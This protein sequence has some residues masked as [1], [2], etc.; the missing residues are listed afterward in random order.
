MKKVL[1]ITPYYPPFPKPGA[2]KRVENFVR[3]LP[4]HG[5]DP[6]LIT[7]DWGYPD[8][9]EMAGRKFFFTRN[10]ARMS[11]RAY[12]IT[13]VEQRR[14]VSSWMIKKMIA[15][16]RT[17]KSYLL[18]PDELILWLFWVVWRMREI[19]RTVGFDVL[20]TTAPPNSSLLVAV[21]AKKLFRIPLICDVRDDWCDNPLM[22]KKSSLLRHIE[23]RME[24]WVVDNAD[25]IILVT[26]SS[27]ELWARR[28]PAH[29]HKFVLVPNGY[30]EEE[31]QAASAYVYPAVA[32]VHV[33]SLELNRSPELVYQALARMR[34][35][36]RIDFYQYGLVLREF[37]DKA[38]EYG[39]SDRVHFEGIIPAA[40]TISRI[41]GA[42]MLVLLPTQNAPTAIPGKTYEYLRTGKPILLISAENATT[43]FMKKF[44]Q[45]YQVRPG[46]IGGCIDA[47][48]KASGCGLG[49]DSG[50]EAADSM[51]QYDRRSLAGD[52]AL[53]FDH[54]IENRHMRQRSCTD[55]T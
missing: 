30:S 14:S 54:V 45:V 32:L 47:I 49:T 18:V 50:P 33:G 17:V 42:S 6:V 37:Q 35:R 11:W 21:A 44:P 36:Q 43:Q 52:L 24:R 25:R 8:A 38:A 2:T 1:I 4:E 22:E 10:I 48:V 46:D 53:A 7:M 9:T 55:R 40:E 39:V 13:E 31:Y 27:R 29:R 34:D 15:F 51:R 3:Y 28:Y 23:K 16:A 19:R 20:Y 5:W 26:G 12:Q 41:K